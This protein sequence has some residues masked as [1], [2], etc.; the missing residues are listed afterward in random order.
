M[1]QP[2]LQTLH[3]ALNELRD[4]DIDVAAFCA[5]WR[6]QKALFAR[7]PPRYEEVAEDVLG[8]LEA[9]SLFSE[10]SCSFSQDDLL[11]NL[12]LWLHKA[13]KTLV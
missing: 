7:L 13:E 1:S 11:N 4:G 9:S 10:E 2:T 3:D 8:R 6:S 12:A 5:R